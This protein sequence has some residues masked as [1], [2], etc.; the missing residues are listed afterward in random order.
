MTDLMKIGQSDDRLK[1]WQDEAIDYASNEGPFHSINLVDHK[2]FWKTMPPEFCEQ[3]IQKFENPI[4]AKAHVDYHIDHIDG[5][6][7]IKFMPSS[8]QVDFFKKELL[9]RWRMPSSWDEWIDLWD[10]HDVLYTDDERVLVDQQKRAKLATDILINSGL[11]N[12][13]VS[14]TMMD[15]HGRQLL[16]I[17]KSLRSNGFD[18]TKV[19]LRIVDKDPDVNNW[20]KV[21][22]PSTMT[23]PIK[24]SIYDEGV[25]PNGILYLNFCGLNGTNRQLIEFI[26][27]H[28]K[29]GDLSRV[30]LSFS[31]RRGENPK[32]YQYFNDMKNAEEKCNRGPPGM[33][34][35]TF[36]FTT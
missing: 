24:G 26:Q 23:T 28:E 3:Q 35:H 19:H 11:K 8:T 4:L 22:F 13:N 17:L 12:K 10:R 6:R 16:T 30:M 32:T 36:Y 15:G 29:L 9:S 7:R 21:F 34:F 31:S 5:R 14:I 27:D 33:G 1:K 2:K 25:P 18:L 20:H